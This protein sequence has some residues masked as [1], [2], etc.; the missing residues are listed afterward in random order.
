MIRARRIAIAALAAFVLAAPA[1]GQTTAQ[2]LAYH[3]GA[4]DFD[5]DFG[6]WKTHSSR[7]LHPLTT[8]TD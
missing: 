5:F 2:S 7:L 1:I 6:T 8:W 3:D 4:H